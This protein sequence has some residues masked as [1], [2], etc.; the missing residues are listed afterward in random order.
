MALD[1]SSETLYVHWRITNQCNYRCSYCFSAGKEQRLRSGMA[2]IEQVRTAAK[3][4]A[5]ANRT[6]YRVILVGGEP[7][8]YPFL[9]ETILLLLASLGEKLEF[10]RI[11]TNGSL[12]DSQIETLIDIG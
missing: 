7:T 1:R 9:A 3:N 4:L 6:H 11:I 8:T 2:S 5:A 12:S 10:V